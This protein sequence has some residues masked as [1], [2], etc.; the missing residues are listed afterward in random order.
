MLVGGCVLDFKNF[1][2]QPSGECIGQQE[3]VRDLG[4]ISTTLC[5]REVLYVLTK[6]LAWNV[7]NTNGSIFLTQDQ[8][9]NCSGHFH[10]QNSVS[11]QLCGFDELYNGNGAC[12]ILTLSS[13]KQDSKYKNTLDLCSNFSS[14]YNDACTNCTG[15]ILDARDHYLSQLHLNNDDNKETTICGLAVVVSVAAANVNNKSLMDDFYSCLPTLDE[16]GKSYNHY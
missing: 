9:R 8:W 12:S 10:R 3:R 14:S 15:A 5:C 6:A 1:P 7:G 2:Y 4:S 13:I 16:F 11:P